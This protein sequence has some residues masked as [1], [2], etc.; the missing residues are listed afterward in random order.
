M[1]AAL[2]DETYVHRSMKTDA[3]YMAP[4]STRT[5]MTLVRVVGMYSLLMV[6]FLTLVCMD[7]IRAT[8]RAVR[9]VF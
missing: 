2:L 7:H 4:A 6:R 3:V 5:A 9:R 1:Y 8:I